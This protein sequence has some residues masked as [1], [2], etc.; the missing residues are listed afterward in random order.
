MKRFKISPW[1]GSNLD[2]PK[3]CDEL[4]RQVTVSPLLSAAEAEGILYA[5]LPDLE[6]VVQR[7]PPDE[8]CTATCAVDKLRQAF[9]ND[10]SHNVWSKPEAIQIPEEC[11]VSVDGGNCNSSVWHDRNRQSYF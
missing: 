7:V 3:S 10:M 8:W 4:F 9:K 2:K 6:P 1:A 5:M 11:S